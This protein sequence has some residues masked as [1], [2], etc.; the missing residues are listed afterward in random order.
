M[1]GYGR[2]ISGSFRIEARSTNQRNLDVRIN[3]PSYL[4]SIEPDIKKKVRLKFQRGRIEIFIQM[5]NEENIKLKINKSLAKE[6]Y[7][8]LVSLKKDLSIREEV[9]INVLAGQRDIFSIEEPEIDVS[10]LYEALDVTLEDLTKMR[11]EEG[12][13]LT[14]DISGRLDLLQGYITDIEGKREDFTAN[15][16]KVLTE[17]L[18]TILSDTSIDDSRIVQEA[19]IIVDRS[20]ITEEIVR[21]KNHLKHAGEIIGNLS[22]IGKKMD[23]LSQELYREINTIGTKAAGSGISA[24]VIEMKHEIEKIR[25]QAQNLQ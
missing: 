23:F 22:V 19:A 15:A 3:M 17:R 25:E 2:G 9:G 11:E 6:Y 14:E 24:L 21:F 18:K 20:D 13:F 1:T 8:A 10:G 12:E 7:R 4:Y 16:H 5:T